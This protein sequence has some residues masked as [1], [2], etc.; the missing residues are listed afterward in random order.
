MS[1]FADINALVAYGSERGLI[2]PL[3]ETY[4]KNRLINVLKIDRFRDE[5]KFS[6]MGP[7]G[8]WHRVKVGPSSGRSEE[9]AR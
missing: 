8:G 1:V 5:K 3:D 7:R 4:I 2:S 9:I 6:S